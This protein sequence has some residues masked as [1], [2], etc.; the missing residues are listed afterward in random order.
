M[1]SATDPSTALTPF[2]SLGVELGLWHGVYQNGQLPWL[3][4]WDLQGNLLLTGE[5][6][7]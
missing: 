4:W 2:T 6:R 5:E 1:T 7:A 3:G